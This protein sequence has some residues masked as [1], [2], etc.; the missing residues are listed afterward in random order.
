MDYEKSL[1][2][3]RFETKQLNDPLSSEEAEVKTV[4]P[5]TDRQREE[6]IK[7][8]FVKVST[9]FGG[10]GIDVHVLCSQCPLAWKRQVRFFTQFPITDSQTDSLGGFVLKQFDGH[11]ANVAPPTKKGKKNPFICSLIVF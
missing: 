8:C 3:Y 2:F 7:V 9:L 6:T 11:L 4:T 10:L 1:E 5:P